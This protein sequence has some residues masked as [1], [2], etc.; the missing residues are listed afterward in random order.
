VAEYVLND[1]QRQLLRMLVPGLK[2]EKIGLQWDVVLG[3]NITAIFENGKINLRS[4]GWHHA[5]H[6]DF[7]QFVN[8]GFFRVTKHNR[9]GQP[10]SYA[11][12]DK[13]IIQAVENDFRLPSVTAH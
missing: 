6:H 7:D 2:Q 11:L 8:Q 10:S 13:L 5:D 1:K 4:L 12:D 3:A 9:I